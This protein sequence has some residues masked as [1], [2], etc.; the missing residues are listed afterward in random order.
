MPNEIMHVKI[1][2]I[3][4][5]TVIEKKTIASEEE[6]KFEVLIRQPVGYVHRCRS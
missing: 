4:P 3:N 5:S 6:L 1:S 2:T